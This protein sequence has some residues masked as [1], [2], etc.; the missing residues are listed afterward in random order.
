MSVDTGGSRPQM[1]RDRAPAALAIEGLSVRYPA[2]REPSLDGVDLAV[3]HGRAGRR[4]R[5]DRRGQVDARAGG[6]RVHPEGRPGARRRAR[7]DRRPGHG[8]RAAGGPDRPG[9][10]RLRDA[11]QPA[12]GIEADRPRGAGL[13]A[14]EPRRPARRDGPADRCDPG[15]PRHRATSPT[16]S[17][18]PCP[19][20]SSNGWRSPAS[21]RWAPRSSSST[22]RP[23]S[24][25]RRGRQRSRHCSTPW[26][27]TAGRSSASS[28]I[29]R[30]SAGWIGASSSRAG[31]RSSLDRPGVA[32]ERAAAAGRARGT[33]PRPARGG[34]RDGPGPGLRRGGG[35]GRTGRLGHPPRGA[36]GGRRREPAGSRDRH[37]DVDAD[38]RATT[39]PHRDRAA[40]PPLPDRPRGGSRRVAVDRAGRDGRDPRPERLG[41]DDARE[42]PRRPA[43]T[44][45]RTRPARRRQPPTAERSRNWPPPSGSCSRTRTTSCSNARWSGRWRSGRATSA[46]RRRRS[47]GPSPRRWPPSG[48]PISARPTRTTWTCPD[49]S[50]SRWRASS[51][52]TRRSSSSTSRRPARTP[53]A[54]PG[55]A[56]WSTRCAAAGRTVIAITHDMEFAATRFGRIV[57]MRDGQVVADG[58]PSTVFAPA[59]PRRPRIDRADATAGGEDRRPDGPADRAAGRRTPCC[60]ALRARD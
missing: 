19:A 36:R 21:W 43:A 11:R 30:C 3:A 17:R 34:R 52:W 27:A 58:P 60:A 41:Q 50:W 5:S 51:P 4:G 39:R 32:L 16:A 47:P 9:R 55:S 40:G 12:V 33:D 2:R 1:R 7:R 28:T 20:A 14:R 44:G 25:T 35:R 8:D 22:N 31:D 49:A 48:S 29:R 13:R 46:C 23:P 53:R 59:E 45:L 24:S 42:A 37:V 54:S 18:S 57:V 15:P 56:P 26:R 38:P 6:G 10:D